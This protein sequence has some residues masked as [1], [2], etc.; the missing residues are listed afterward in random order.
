MIE[1]LNIQIKGMNDFFDIRPQIRDFLQL[2]LPNNYFLVEVALNEAINNVFLHGSKKAEGSI[3]LRI[4]V[5]N[6][7]LIIRLKNEGEGFLANQMLKE[8]RDSTENP[9][10]QRLFDESGR[11]LPIMDSA[12]DY[13]VYNQQGNEVMF[14]KEQG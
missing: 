14:M 6:R 12:F 4:K 8:I 11:G 2:A 5:T 1:P 10:E 3:E 13:M 9:F 7:K